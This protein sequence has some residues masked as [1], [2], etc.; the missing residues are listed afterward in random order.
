VFAALVPFMCDG[1]TVADLFIPNSVDVF[2]M[3]NMDVRVR[4]IPFVPN[5]A[6][7]FHYK[8]ALTS[9]SFDVI[10]DD[11]PTS[12]TVAGVVIDQLW[13]MQMQPWHF[14]LNVSAPPPRQS[15]A[16]DF[17]SWSSSLV[18]YPY[19]GPNSNWF[20]WRLQA[21]AIRW[22]QA[23]GDMDWWE[24]YA[25]RRPYTTAPEPSTFWIG[26][27]AVAA[28]AATRVRRS[29]SSRASSRVHFNSAR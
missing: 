26:G 10:T 8:S 28:F 7:H 5:Y 15:Q 2:G 19:G 17:E 21:V 3:G 4:Q 25:T 18:P 12:L 20:T 14:T 6:E 22:S 13:G 23:E 9:I 27:V 1:A 29:V 24:F 11:D 16:V